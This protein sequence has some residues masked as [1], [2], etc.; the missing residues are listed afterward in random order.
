MTQVA[1]VY[2]TCAP[3]RELEAIDKVATKIKLQAEATCCKI[4]LYSVRWCP[5]LN[6][7][8]YTNLVLQR[9]TQEDQRWTH[10]HTISYLDGQMGQIDTLYNILTTGAINNKHIKVH[11]AYKW[12]QHLKVDKGYHDT[13]ISNLIAT[14]AVATNQPRKTLWKN[15]SVLKK[16]AITQG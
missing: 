13:W 12:Y 16:Y 6:N 7:A 10:Q 8:Y 2:L 14:Q 1:H 3:Q 5:C 15:Y 11:Q 4:S 9:Q